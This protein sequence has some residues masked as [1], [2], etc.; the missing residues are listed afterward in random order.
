VDFFVG[1]LFSRKRKL[2]ATGTRGI[3]FFVMKKISLSLK[4]LFLCAVLA[5][6]T[7]SV[8]SGCVQSRQERAEK[9]LAQ[10]VVV[11]VDHRG[12]V[13][14]ENDVIK[15]GVFANRIRAQKEIVAGKPV[16]LSVNPEVEVNQPAIVP[17]IRRVLESVNVGKIYDAIPVSLDE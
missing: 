14:Y 12:Y 2:P 8:A 11:E 17:Y 5:A 7:L 9:I 15:P 13:R 1:T 3:F 6:G 10:M 16:L 4:T